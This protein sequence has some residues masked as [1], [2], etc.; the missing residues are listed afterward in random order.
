VESHQR[1]VDGWVSK[2]DVT[3]YIRCPY[4]WYLLDR[5]EIPF[6]DTINEFQ[7]KLIRN[8]RRFHR[9]TGAQLEARQVAP[10]QL[11]TA[12]DEIPRRSGTEVWIPTG[13]VEDPDR[14][15]YGIPDGVVPAGGALYPIEIKSHAH[16][17]PTDRLELAFY[18]LL[19]EQWRAPGDH[20]PLGILYL[21]T[22]V[23]LE[24]VEV[25]LLQECFK[26]LA[27]YVERVRSARIHGVR[28]RVCRC[29]SCRGLRRKE[30]LAAAREDRDVTLIN[31]IAITRADRLVE[32]GI[33]TWED[34][35]EVDPEQIQRCLHEQQDHVGLADIERWRQHARAYQSETPVAFGSRPDIGEKFIALDLEY[36]GVGGRIWL[37]GLASSTVSRLSIIC[38]GRPTHGRRSRRSSRSRG[39]PQSTQTCQS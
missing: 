21:R 1:R 3:Q 18:W 13:V 20:E 9:S 8:G 31:G 11:S 12:V 27:E 16:Q 4:S 39:S 5:R 28:P 10:A 24:K 29:P 35:L 2:T 36:T 6:S 32:I 7:S 33:G 15:L 17:A 23:G 14:K 38:S 30:V 25:P 26:D 22:R 37:T 34:L 19:L